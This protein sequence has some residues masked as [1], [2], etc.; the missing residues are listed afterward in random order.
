MIFD[1]VENVIDFEL[2]L[3][4]I[5]SNLSFQRVIDDPAEKINQVLGEQYLALFWQGIM[6]LVYYIK[7][8]DDFS[9][10]IDNLVVIRH[11]RWL[12]KSA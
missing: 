5:S 9:I 1:H 10:A 7:V 12:H 2:A 8:L 11:G 3:I 6:I 4:W